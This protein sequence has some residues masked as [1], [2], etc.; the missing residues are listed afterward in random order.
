[1]T[2]VVVERRRTGWDIIF[3]ILL[4][5]AGIAILGDVVVATTV[6]VKFLGWMAVISGLVGLVAAL[7]RI[8]KSGF[9]SAALGSGL[10][11]VL[12]VVILRNTAAT[13]VVLTLV[14]GAI[15]FV[16]GI[17]RLAA[18]NEYPQARWVL[19]IGGLISVALGLIVLFNLATASFTLLGILLG[20]QALIEGVTLIFTG[21][22]HVDAVS[23]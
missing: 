12:G 22:T 2:A 13:A 3:G 14:A 1:M 17:A 23:S 19:I 18:A 7:F 15:F 21:R 9:W 6:S 8:N 10:M 5:I 4:L 20:V 16:G 11:L